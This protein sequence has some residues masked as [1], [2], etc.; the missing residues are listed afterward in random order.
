MKRPATLETYQGLW[1]GVIDEE[2]VAAESTSHALALTLHR[3]DYRRRRRVV[4]EF[5]R[6]QT[7]S[8]IVGVG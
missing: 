3:M 4:V 8:Y 6:P 2:V 5:V 7:D 1:V